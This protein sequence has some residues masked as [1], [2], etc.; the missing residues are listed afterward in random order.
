MPVGCVIEIDSE[1]NSLAGTAISSY[2]DVS[3]ESFL[4]HC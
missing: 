1:R 4:F 3:D 2:E